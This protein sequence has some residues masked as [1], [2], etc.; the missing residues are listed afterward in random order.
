MLDVSAVRERFPALQRL[1][2]G[3]PVLFF[4]NPAGT[5]VPQEMIDGLTCYLQRSNAN[6]GGDFATSRQ[7]DLIIAEARAAM[8]DFLG[9]AS[10]GEIVFGQNMTSLTFHLSHALRAVLRPG[11]EVVTTRLEH[12]ANVAPWL[13][14][15]AVGVAV[16]FIDMRPED[17]TLDLEDAERVITER[18]RLLAVGY[19]SNAMGTIN[20]VARLARTAH[21]HGALVFVD[22]VHYGPHGSIDV[23]ALDCDFLAC[24]PYKFFGP[25]LGVLYGRYELLRSIPAPHVRPAGD[26]PPS[27]WETGTQSHE[28]LSGLLGTISYLCSLSSGEGDRRAQ[29]RE[30]MARIR[31]YEGALARRL[32]S[33]LRSL[34]SVAVY[35]IVDE[36]ALVHRVPTVSF[37]VD[38]RS[39][40]QISAALAERG[41]FSWAG[42]HYAVEPLARLGLEATGRVGLVHYNTLE[43]VDRF[44]QTLEEVVR[45]GRE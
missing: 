18:T 39:P 38:G 22:A 35:G 21:A 8:A 11:D 15:R 12:D 7:T 5:Q 33:G 2:H 34:P 1:H 40:F 25:H 37:T 44:L 27:S 20:D 28:A 29:L 30:A 42:N 17:C 6:T 14:L 26:Q 24:S 19:A 3:R 23:Q 32:I 31:R 41:I 45:I 36:P 4:D 9:A 43:E 10:P 16:R 13:A